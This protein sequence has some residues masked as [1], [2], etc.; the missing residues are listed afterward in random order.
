[1]KKKKIKYELRCFIDD[2]LTMKVETF[3]DKETAVESAEYESKHD[4]DRIY[5]VKKIT[6]QMVFIIGKRV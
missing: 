5:F 2:N 4:D 1:M 3:T 6:E